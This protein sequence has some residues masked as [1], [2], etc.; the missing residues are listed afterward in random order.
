MSGGLGLG[1]WCLSSLSTII[2]LYR[3]RQQ[4]RDLLIG[5]E[6]CIKDDYMIKFYL[7]YSKFLHPNIVKFIGVCFDCHPRYIILELLEG[8]DLKTFLREMR[9]KPTSLKVYT[10]LFVKPMYTCNR[11]H[12][13]QL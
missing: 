11:F 13:H 7:L 8:G 10:L 5:S 1:L 12:Y 4:Y 3:G 9:P 6:V 2:Q